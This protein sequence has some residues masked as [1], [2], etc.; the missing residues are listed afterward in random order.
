[1]SKAVWIILCILIVL[2]LGIGGYFIYKKQIA[3]TE[4]AATSSPEKNTDSPKVSSKNNP[5]GPY[6]HQIYSA[7]SAD[8]L[9]WQKQDKLLFD[10]ASV[11]GAV[12]KGNK[13]YLYFV[14][15]SYDEDQLSVVT[16]TDNGQTFSE[17]QK[18][19]V[20]DTPTYATVD[21]HPELISGK[22][23]LYYFS[24]PMTPDNPKEPEV[25]RMYSAIS[26]DGVN[27]ENPQ[28]A[29]ESSEIITDPDVFQTDKDWRMFISKGQDLVLA[30]STDNGLT[31]QEDKSFSW[32][33]GGVCDTIKMDGLYRTYFCGQGGIGSAVGAENGKLTVEQGTRIESG[34]GQIVCDPSV[35]QLSDNTYLMFYKTQ[36]PNQQGDQPSG[37]MPQNPPDN[38]PQ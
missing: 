26:D 22:I 7:A 10:H 30:I 4:T 24:N 1:M 37:N 34:A 16:S 3:A 12:V 5:N 13:I 29:F 14:D 25:F 6:Y 18:V 15:A 38:P 23:R 21:P 19:K 28:I 36:K 8:G 35:V 11:P 9:A 2:G 20:Q 27:F 17:K 33:E 31:F 32:N